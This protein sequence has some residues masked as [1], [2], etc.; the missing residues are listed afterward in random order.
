MP[1]SQNAH[2]VKV[3]YMENYSIVVSHIEIDG[4]LTVKESHKIAHEIQ[5]KILEENQKSNMLYS[6]LPNG[7]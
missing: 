5:N 7:S 1:N 4:E 6:Y 3:D 2:E